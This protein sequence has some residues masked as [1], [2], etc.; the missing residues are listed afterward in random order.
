MPKD[1]NAI[2]D[3]ESTGS[4]W[5]KLDDGDSVLAVL[6][7]VPMIARKHIVEDGSAYGKRFFCGTPEGLGCPIC[8]TP[9]KFTLKDPRPKQEGFY[10][11]WV[12]SRTTGGRSEDMKRMM[13]LSGGW[14]VIGAFKSAKES[15]EMDGEG[16][17]GVPL[18]ITRE[19]K[20]PQTRYTIIP[21]PNASVTIEG[22][23]ID[24]ENIACKLIL[25]DQESVNYQPGKET[26]GDRFA[27]HPGDPKPA[28]TSGYPD[29]DRY[30]AL[31]G[32]LMTA[33]GFTDLDAFRAWRQGAGLVPTTVAD[34]PAMIERLEKDLAAA[35][36]PDPAS[37]FD[38]DVEYVKTT[39]EAA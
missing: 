25:K 14:S 10:P 1:W 15:Q 26:E 37:P 19:G 29:R 30:N 36:A 22:D 4:D 5:L 8:E 28:P 9:E 13:I 23:P 12:E 7:D 33:K 17:Q 35:T 24:V 31:C 21:K 18:R 6:V 3:S 32:E 39:K 11:L 2:E 16:I 34:L 20:G 27:G 38:W